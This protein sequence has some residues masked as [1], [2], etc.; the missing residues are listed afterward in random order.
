MVKSIRGNAESENTQAWPSALC[1][2][3]CACTHIC[4]HVHVLYECI[5]KHQQCKSLTSRHV[6]K[7][8]KKKNQRTHIKDN[9]RFSL[10]ICASMDSD[11]AALHD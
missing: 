9:L 4:V 11:E 5:E 2:C 6:C 10:C 7:E 1:E 8:Q 3:I